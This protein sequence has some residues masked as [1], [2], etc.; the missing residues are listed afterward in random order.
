MMISSVTIGLVVECYHL[1]PEHPE[2]SRIKIGR[3]EPCWTRVDARQ[4]AL[5]EIQ[6]LQGCLLER[7]L[8]R[9]F[10]HGKHLGTL[11]I[12]PSTSL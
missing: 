3:V 2:V 4:V 10:R 5:V 6:K 9:F 1:A 7:L 11:Q 8:G 12:F